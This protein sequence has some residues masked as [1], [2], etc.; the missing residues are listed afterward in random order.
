MGFE[1]EDGIVEILEKTRG[2]VIKALE[3]LLLQREI[4][5]DRPP[6]D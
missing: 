1:E 6:E 3:E 5:F 4:R 2:D